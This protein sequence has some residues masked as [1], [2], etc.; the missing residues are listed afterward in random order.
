MY[1]SATL[2]HTFFQLFSL[3]PGIDAIENKDD[4]R[5][6]LESSLLTALYIYYWQINMTT[7]DGAT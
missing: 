2:V 1:N 6:S 4:R 7:M 3:Q 5:T